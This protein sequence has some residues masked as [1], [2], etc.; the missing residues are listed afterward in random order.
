MKEN[1][2]V[3]LVMILIF[4]IIIGFVALTTPKE[5][6]NSEKLNEITDEIG[7]PG[8]LEFVRGHWTD[9]EIMEYLYEK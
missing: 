7:I 9:Y 2:S 3:Y 1:L 5:K 6:T 8:I 4:A